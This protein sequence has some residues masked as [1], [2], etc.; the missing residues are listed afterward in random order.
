VTRIDSVRAATGS[1]RGSVL[2]AAEVVAPYA[3][4]ARD[5]ATHYAREAQVRLAPKV[6]LAAGQARARYVAHLAPRIRRARAHVPPKVDEAALRARETARLA[7][8]ASLPRIEQ[9][10][11][12]AG[13]VRQQ[14][15]DRSAATLAALRGQ[16]SAKEIQRIVRRRRRR[17]QAGRAAMGALLLG[18]A[19]GGA[20]AAWKWWDKQAHPDWLVEPPAATE[21]PDSSRLSSVD[22]SGDAESLDPRVRAR[23]EDARAAERIARERRGGQRR[24]GQAG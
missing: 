16:I 11:A 15:M 6:A 1:A 7:A 8:A 19:A 22:G 12:A 3:D 21:E 23:Q 14:A 13:P 20:F 2:H 5:R 17:A 24:K 9:A 10:V 4:T 18:L